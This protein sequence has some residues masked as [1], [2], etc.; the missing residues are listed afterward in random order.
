MSTKYCPKTMHAASR[1][2]FLEKS[3]L[4]FGALAAS[5]L[6]DAAPAANPF[7]LCLNLPVILLQNFLNDG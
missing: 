4:G 1:R 2:Q 7:A 5:S 6:L 3:G